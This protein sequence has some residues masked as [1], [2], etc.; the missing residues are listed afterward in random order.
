MLLSPQIAT[1]IDGDRTWKVQLTQKGKSADS[2]QPACLGGDP[3][4]GQPIPQQSL[5]RVLN[6]TGKNPPAVLQQSDA[7]ATPEEAAQ[8]YAVAAKTL[9]GCSMAA[10]Y[11]D[12]GAVVTGVGDQSVGARAAGE[13]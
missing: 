7:Y 8:A 13:R 3:V 5:L 10:T 2:P 12:S 6:S 9:G 1:R 4:E 11:I